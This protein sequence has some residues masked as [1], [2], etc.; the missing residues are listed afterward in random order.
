MDKPGW[1]IEEN[2]RGYRQT[3]I[4]LTVVVIDRNCTYVVPAV[5]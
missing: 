5:Y 3:F 4:L 2:S 1:P